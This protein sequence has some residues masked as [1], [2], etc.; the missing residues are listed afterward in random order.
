MNRCTPQ[1]RVERLRVIHG[2]LSAVGAVTGV[3]VSQLSAIR[4]DRRKPNGS[5]RAGMQ[6]IAG[7]GLDPAS[8][9]DQ[10][11]F[12]VVRQFP[13]GP[14]AALNTLKQWRSPLT[15]EEIAEAY[16]GPDR[17][18][19]ARKA[20]AELERMGRVRKV[21]KTEWGPLWVAA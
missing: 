13:R 20:L 10:G 16:T 9:D 12:I 3:T 7:I 21:G 14:V 18:N 15:D 6:A 8:E 1:E 2:S 11:R 4:Y 19:Q 17:I 5:R